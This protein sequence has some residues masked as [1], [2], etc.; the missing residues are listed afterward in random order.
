M[1]TV[2]T[3]KQTSPKPF[4]NPEV[5]LIRG[6]ILAIFITSIN[7]SAGAQNFQGTQ[8][9]GNQGFA[10]NNY[11]QNYPQNY[12]PDY[13]PGNAFN[14]NPSGNVFGN[15]IANPGTNPYASLEPGVKQ[16]SNFWTSLANIPN[17]LNPHILANGTVFNGVLQEDISSKTSK[18]GDVFSIMLS[19]DYTMNNQ[20]LIP[21]ESRFVGSVVSVTPAKTTRNGAPGNL[22]VSMQTLV[23]PDG[24]S[25][26]VNAFI[27]YD[28]SQQT[29]TD[30]KKSRGVPVGEW[31]K[32]AEYMMYY[33]A[34]GLGSRL[35]VPFLYKGQ[36]AHGPDFSLKQGQLLPVRL[37]QPLD[38]TPL[39]ESC[40]RASAQNASPN[41]DVAPDRTPT[42]APSL[43]PPINQSSN[44]ATPPNIQAVPYAQ[45]SSGVNTLPGNTVPAGPEPF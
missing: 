25:I 5:K 7:L 24:V 30:I 11:T 29:K 27:D 45:Q 8:P 40:K 13:P 16:T 21:K 9:M 38:V 42:G 37:S 15:P 44:F 39:A 14:N 17:L 19:D 35:G 12:Q 3:I 34:G 20:L 28:A 1:L 10:P 43:A 18:A 26:P 6:F 33:A 23:T 32:S 31:A 36:T 2:K 41:P 4:I 22:Q